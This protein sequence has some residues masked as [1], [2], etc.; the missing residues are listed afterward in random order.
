MSITIDH[1]GRI[2]V[3]K[4]IRDALNLTPGTRL[5]IEADGNEIRLRVAD[6]EPSL[7]Q[8]DEILI[9]H[10]AEKSSLDI[11]AFIRKEREQQAQKEGHSD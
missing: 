10:G 5:E 6:L 2:V 8:K 1:A 9:H 11:A 7:L 3:P 4:S